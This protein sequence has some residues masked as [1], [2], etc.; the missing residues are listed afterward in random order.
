MENRSLF[1]KW[2]QRDPT[3]YTKYLEYGR[4]DQ[5]EKLNLLLKEDEEKMIQF[6]SEKYSGSGMLSHVL[7]IIS[8]R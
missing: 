5:I 4:P 3:L 8:L 6:Y 2:I 1:I 7:K